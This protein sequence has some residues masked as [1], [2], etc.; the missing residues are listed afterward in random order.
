M[1]R[2]GDVC[3][4]VTGVV[5]AEVVFGVSEDFCCGFTTARGASGGT[6]ENMFVNESSGG[7]ASG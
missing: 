7:S 2:C 5:T 3:A 6:D 4:G 1:S